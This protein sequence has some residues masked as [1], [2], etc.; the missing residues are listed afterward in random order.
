MT[1]SIVTGRN[2]AERREIH[3]QQQIAAD[4]AMYGGS[5]SKYEPDMSE[6]QP[7]RHPVP[8]GPPAD[9]AVTLC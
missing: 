7:G 4:L 6:G 9:R 8:T 3:G 2:R 1:A 5:G